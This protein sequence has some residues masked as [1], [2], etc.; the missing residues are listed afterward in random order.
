MRTIKAPSVSVIPRALGYGN[1]QPGNVWEA[2]A[3]E[4]TNPPAA[5]AAPAH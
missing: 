3:E 1:V 5:E 4:D 2:V